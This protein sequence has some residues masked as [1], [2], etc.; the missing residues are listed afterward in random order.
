MWTWVWVGGVRRP[1]K[2]WAAPVA[3]G[4][5]ILHRHPDNMKLWCLTH[6]E[7]GVLLGTAARYSTLADAARLA[8]RITTRRERDLVRGRAKPRAHPRKST[9]D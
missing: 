2:G 6:A 4:S 7:T 1:V 5:L 8:W 9:T 3:R